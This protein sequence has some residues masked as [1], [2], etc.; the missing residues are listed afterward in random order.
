MDDF[1]PN[2]FSDRDGD[3]LE[4]GMEIKYESSS[5]PQGS[6]RSGFEKSRTVY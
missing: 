2:S 1:S 3:E 4:L 6:R 5:H